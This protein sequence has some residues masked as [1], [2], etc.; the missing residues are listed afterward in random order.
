MAELLKIE[1][2]IPIPVKQGVSYSQ[3]RALLLAMDVGDSFLIKRGSISS[4]YGYGKPL[5]FKFKILQVAGSE[6]LARVW[7][8][9]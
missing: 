7:R 6:K 9:A 5:G 8:I 2:N 1:K 3:V 4:V